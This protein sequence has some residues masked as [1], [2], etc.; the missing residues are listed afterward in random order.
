MCE[1]ARALLSGVMLSPD[2]LPG[3]IVASAVAPALLLLW[4]VV[5]ADSRPE[6]P[7]VVWI[8]AGLGA[9]CAIPVGFLEVWLQV[10]VPITG[11]P[12]FAPFEKA[13]LF[14]GLPEEIVKV[15]IIA[16]VALRARDF[17][18]PMDG[19]VY[20]AAVGLGFAAVENVVYLVSAASAWEFVAIMRGLLSVP[21][22]GALGAIAGAY[23]ARARFG[24]ALGAHRTVL[25]RRFR[26]F[27]AAWLIP[28]VLHTLFDGAVFTLSAA[29]SKAAP[30]GGWLVLMLVVALVV[31]IGAI[32]FAIRLAGRIARRQQAVVN[33]KRLPAAHW[34]GIWARSVLGL[35]L[36]FVAV[37]LLIAGN[38]GGRIVGCVLLAIAVALSRHCA[39]YLNDAA[40]Q[41]HR[42]VAA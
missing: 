32:V 34:R 6:P 8:A 39:K 7:R 22:H 16:A 4:L 38:L 37:A 29:G 13:L 31:A 20:G 41:T 5:V 11:D 19:V 30:S 27:A 40:K 28:I 21:F 12:T 26:L 15:S 33:T 3:A 35:G 14:A 18:E 36:S 17:D 10:Q 42:V 24:G 1:P 2:L 25:W 23:I 9:L